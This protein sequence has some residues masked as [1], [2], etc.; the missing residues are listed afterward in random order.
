MIH[1]AKIVNNSPLLD[2]LKAKQTGKSTQRDHKAVDIY[3]EETK[4]LGFNLADYYYFS[5]IKY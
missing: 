2:R 1:S 4:N 3:A 5:K